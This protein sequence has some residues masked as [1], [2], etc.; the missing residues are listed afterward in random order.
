MC[1]N[2]IFA[3]EML[4]N[5]PIDVIFLDIQMPD[6]SGIDLVK[7]L[8]SL[9]QVVLVS[10]KHE[11]GIEAYDYNLTDYLKKPVEYSRFLKAIEKVEKN[12]S[13][14]ILETKGGSNIYVKTDN[15]IVR[16]KLD[17]ILFVEALSDYMI[18]HTDSKKFVIH[19]TMKSL[20]RRLPAKD[21]MRV[22]RS[23]IVNLSKIES[24]ED[25]T[26]F[27]NH[28][29]MQIPVG[30]SYKNDFLARLNML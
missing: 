7:A 12:L 27:V 13:N 28:K 5:N 25:T 6:M 3:I 18:I 10:T 8:D 21:F 17:E 15:K 20:E 9:P 4:K 1:E 2:A 29:Q 11:F 23:Y 24:I 14:N 16:I 19:S 22:H 26:I 30:A